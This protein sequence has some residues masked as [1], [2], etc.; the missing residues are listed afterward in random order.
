MSNA[1]LFKANC[2][3]QI[4]QNKFHEVN[5]TKQAKSKLRKTNLR[6]QIAQ[7]LWCEI[8]LPITKLQK[9]ITQS[10]MYADLAQKVDIVLLAY[11]PL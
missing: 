4:A 9:Q 2:K 3:K 7:T 11:F 1:M 10:K 5:C 8:N 6:K